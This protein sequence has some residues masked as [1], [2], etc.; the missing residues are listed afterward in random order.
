MCG[1]RRFEAGGGEHD[2]FRRFD[3]EPGALDRG[4]G[5]AG[6]VAAARDARPQAAVV[7]GLQEQS[8]GL[9]VGDDVLVEPQLAS[10][11]QDTAQLGEGAV[12]VGDRAEHEAGDG[13]VGAG[14]V[15][16]S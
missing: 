16:S 11:A 3:L 6:G 8:L 10:G 9:A 13:G 14:D 2:A 1:N 5:V 15:V 12:L 4:R 7:D